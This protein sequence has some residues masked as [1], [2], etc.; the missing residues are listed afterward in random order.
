[1]DG[2]PC[3][4]YDR[5]KPVRKGDL[6]LAEEQDLGVRHATWMEESASRDGEEDAAVRGGIARL[7]ELEYQNGL[8]RG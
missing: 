3:Q 2:T 5:R 8:D 7:P 4:Q 1:M 6:H